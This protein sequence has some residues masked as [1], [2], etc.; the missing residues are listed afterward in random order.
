VPNPSFEYDTLGGAP[1]GWADGTGGSIVAFS[2]IPSSTWAKS[3]TKSLQLAASGVPASGGDVYAFLP[4]F[5]AIANAPYSGQATFNVQTANTTPIIQ[6]YWYTSALAFISAATVAG[7]ATATVQTLQFVNQLAPSNAAFGAVFLVLWNGTAGAITCNAYL[8]AILLVQSAT[9]P[10]Y[11]DGGTPG[12][13]W[14][15]VPGNSV[16]WIGGALGV[17]TISQ[18]TRTM[19]G[20]QQS[21]TPT[22]PTQV[23]VSAGASPGSSWGVYIGPTSSP[24]MSIALEGGASNPGV[25]STVSFPL[26]AGWYYEIYINAGTPPIDTVT[27]IPLQ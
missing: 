24:A 12:Y 17:G 18:P 13:H 10:T 25:W 6:V 27:E 23:I 15:G 7:T 19:G 21:N 26:P 16:S 8:D 2:V 20:I 1:A 9:L 3:G 22:V 11:F 5:A 14:A 4:N